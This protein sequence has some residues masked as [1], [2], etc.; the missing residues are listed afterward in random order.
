MLGRTDDYLEKEL[1]LGH[2]GVRAQSLVEDKI[3]TLELNAD[4]DPATLGVSRAKV[5][6]Y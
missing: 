2:R 3:R 1:I 6:D 5:R 4:V